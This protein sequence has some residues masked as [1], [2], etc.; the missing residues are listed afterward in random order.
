[1]RNEK[2]VLRAGRFARKMWKLHIQGWKFEGKS[3][4]DYDLWRKH[5]F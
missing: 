2:T 5:L 3:W 4:S 1:M